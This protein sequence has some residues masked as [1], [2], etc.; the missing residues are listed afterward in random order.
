MGVVMTAQCQV[1]IG[2]DV[3]EVYDALQE[4]A[5]FGGGR[6]AP[7]GGGEKRGAGAAVLDFVV[8]VF[9]PLIPAIAGGG[10]LKALLSLL[11]LT[12]VMDSASASIRCFTRRRTPPSISCP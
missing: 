6:P 1:I 4:I 12:G 5:S 8:G 2:N 10:I 3:I 7:E 9:Q 11:T